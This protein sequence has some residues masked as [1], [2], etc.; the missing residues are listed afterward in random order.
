[1]QGLARIAALF[2]PHQKCPDQGDHDTGSCQD[3][4][5]EHEHGRVVV[6][7]EERG[8]GTEY[9][10]A[11][12]RADI[13]FEQ[14]SA[15][16]GHIPHVVPDVVGDHRRVSGVVFRDARFDLPDQIRTHISGLGVDATTHTGKQGDRARPEGEPGQDGHHLQEIGLWRTG[17]EETGIDNEQDRQTQHTQPDHAEPH[18]GSP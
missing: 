7:I 9:Q 10:C 17:L 11:D 4:R 8:V 13:G 16:P 15:H 12:D 1:M 3:H 2:R 14:I 5:Q 18:D 6:A